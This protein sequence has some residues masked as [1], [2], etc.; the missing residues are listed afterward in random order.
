M[1]GKDGVE[2]AKKLNKAIATQLQAV[3]SHDLHKMAES[4]KHGE[5][6]TKEGADNV[7][8]NPI[9]YYLAKY[10]AP[11]QLHK[12]ADAM[13]QNKAGAIQENELLGVFYELV[14]SAAITHFFGGNLT[15]GANAA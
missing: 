9:L 13:E 11:E 14:Y 2:Y 8:K 12:L 3:E 4:V 10:F 15:I 6:V 7:K 5:E 1:F